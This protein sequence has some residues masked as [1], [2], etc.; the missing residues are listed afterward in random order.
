MGSLQHGKGRPKAEQGPTTRT[1]PRLCISGAQ[2]PPTSPPYP[3]PRHSGE[4]RNPRQQGPSPR[5]GGTRTQQ[6]GT[7]PPV[8]ASTSPRY[9]SSRICRWHHRQADG[10]R[11]ATG[12]GSSHYLRLVADGLPEAT[13]TTARPRDAKLPVPP[14][15]LKT[16]QIRGRPPKAT[17]ATHRD[18]AAGLS[19]AAVEDTSSETLLTPTMTAT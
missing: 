8:V 17:G 19:V 3:P 12:L 9:E 4:G 14:I 15:V 16:S 6:T 5:C 10:G 2:H 18:T 13:W 1:V 7:A 11:R